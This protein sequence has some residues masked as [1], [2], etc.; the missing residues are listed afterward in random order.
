[1][2]SGPASPR[3][4]RRHYPQP[5]PTEALM[6]VIRASS[7]ANAPV[8]LS[9]KDAEDERARILAA[10]R[11]E[12]ARIRSAAQAEGFEIGFKQGSKKGRDEGFTQSERQVRQAIA[13]LTA[14]IASF[15]VL[16]H[17]TA[18]SLTRELVELAVAIAERVT[19]R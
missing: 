4:R 3:S 6:A 12:A 14:A 9:L 16:R 7:L 18:S 19:K 15:D 2:R 5:S 10:A 8:M 17:E 13:V 11:D 1:H